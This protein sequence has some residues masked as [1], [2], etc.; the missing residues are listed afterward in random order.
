MY[1]ENLS[2]LICLQAIADFL[3]WLAIGDG[4][5]ERERVTNTLAISVFAVYRKTNEAVV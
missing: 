3:I 5:R 1:T 4:E 2:E